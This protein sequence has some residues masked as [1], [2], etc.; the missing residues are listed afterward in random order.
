MSA[1][2]VAYARAHWLALAVLVAVMV[3]IPVALSLARDDDYESRVA[4]YKDGPAGGQ[5]TPEQLSQY[6]DSLIPADRVARSAALNVDFPLDRATVIEDTSL[7]VRP[8]EGVDLVVKSGTPDRATE[9]AQLES[10][11]VEN[12]ATRRSGSAGGRFPA[13]PVLV[14]RLGDRSLPAAR[15]RKIQA[16][17]DALIAQLHAST[18]RL[19]ARSAATT[20]PVS[21]GIDELVQ[22][23][24]GDFSP[25]PG[26]FAAAIGGLALALGLFTAMA[27][28]ASPVV[29]APR[30]GE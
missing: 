26:P 23:L 4:L 10:S 3:V 14:T 15:R 6:I 11:L 13:I 29:T 9:V 27:L 21:G 17:L 2:I 30:R 18:P 19:E 16:R 24:P 22:R 12:L 1:R 20:E 28:L 5:R 25:N 8:D 7:E